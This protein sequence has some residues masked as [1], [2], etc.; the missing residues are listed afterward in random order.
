MSKPS[1]SLVIHDGAFERQH[2]GLVMASAAAAIGREVVILF[3]GQAVHTLRADYSPPEQDS[4]QQ[5]KGAAGFEE[6]LCACR[7]LGAQLLVCEAALAIEGLSADDLR[8]D[9]G[10]EIGG[11]V[12]F[13]QAAGDQSNM[14]F[15]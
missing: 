4:A 7:D 9:L 6:L 15:V 11:F 1:F 12:S 10:L 2:Y 14:M 8:K 3:A 5:K 13:L